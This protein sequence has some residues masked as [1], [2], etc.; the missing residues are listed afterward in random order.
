MS[1]QDLYNPYQDTGILNLVGLKRIVNDTF[2][3][4]LGLLNNIP[5]WVKILIGV[6]FAVLILGGVVKLFKK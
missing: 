6:L 3:E 1:R 4:L 2:N 5:Q